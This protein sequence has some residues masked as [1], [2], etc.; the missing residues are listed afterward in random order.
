MDSSLAHLS[1]CL[2]AGLTFMQWNC[3]YFL[4][5]GPQ[6]QQYIFTTWLS[7]HSFGG[8]M[9][10]CVRCDG[11]SYYMQDPQTAPHEQERQ[12]QS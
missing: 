1:I 7:C 12:F 8:K 6:C 2:T 3:M 10:T 9:S 11:T 5:L 4:L